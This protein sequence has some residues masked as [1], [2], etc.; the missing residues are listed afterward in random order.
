MPLYFFDTHNGEHLQRDTDGI[1]L[2]DRASA[3]AESHITL[4][5]MA[6]DEM[7]DGDMRNLYV[8]VFDEDRSPIYTI[9]MSTVGRWLDR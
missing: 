3:R 5:H 2:P 9:S 7:P 6:K 1:D 8:N 4:G